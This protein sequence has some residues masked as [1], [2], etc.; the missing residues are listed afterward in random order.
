MSDSKISDDLARLASFI[1]LTSHRRSV[2]GFLPDRLDQAVLD[3]IF[4]TANHAPSNA[5]TQPWHTYVASGALR[6]RLSQRLQATV[7]KGEN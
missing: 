4:E 1:E 7:G 3:S 6:D 5:N 2:R